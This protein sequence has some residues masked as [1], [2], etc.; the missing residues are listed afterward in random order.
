MTNKIKASRKPAMRYRK[1]AVDPNMKL[2]ASLAV[3]ASITT[4]ETAQ[5]EAERWAE[6]KRGWAKKA[7][8]K[9]ADTLDERAHEFGYASWSE[10]ESAVIDRKA[11]VTRRPRGYK[12]R[13]GPKKSIK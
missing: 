7:N 3:P 9:R 2:T 8:D 13:R 5:A 11:K 10:A 4:P 1:K 6:R 12:P